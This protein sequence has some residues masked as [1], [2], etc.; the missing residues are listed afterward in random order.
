MVF[1]NCKRLGF[2]VEREEQTVKNVQQNYIRKASRFKNTSDN[3]PENGETV[4]FIR[5]SLLILF[6]DIE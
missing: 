6:R 5:A 2:S 3:L 4:F 1:K